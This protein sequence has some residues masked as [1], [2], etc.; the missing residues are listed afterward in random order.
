M[1]VVI[2]GAPGID[3]LRWSAAHGADVL[4]GHSSGLAQRPTRSRRFPRGCRTHE[5]VGEPPFHD[6]TITRPA[7]AN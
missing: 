6:V 5:A 2:D 3:I 7:Y 4:R 1:H